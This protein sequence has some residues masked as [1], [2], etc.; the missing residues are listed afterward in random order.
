MGI[1]NI[2]SQLEEVFDIPGLSY[3]PDFI[4]TQ[5]EE[6][7]IRIIDEQPW[8]VDFKR[9]V[10]HYGYRYDYKARNI[11]SD[12]KIGNI[13]IW[14]IPLCEKLQSEGLLQP[15]PDQVIINEYQPGQGIAPHIDCVPCFGDIIASLSLSS[16]CVMD[17]T[18]SKTKQTKAHLLEAR[19]LIVLSKDA[20]YK[21][22]HGIAPRKTDKLNDKVVPRKRRLSL[23]FRTVFLE[24]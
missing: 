20:R 24:T 21:W 19:S 7:L 13:P 6:N 22:R 2:E 14:L 9:R 10:Q 15:I 12:L 23:T 18:H 1:Q 4:D 17:F 5:T 16:A 3:I 11:S 8:I